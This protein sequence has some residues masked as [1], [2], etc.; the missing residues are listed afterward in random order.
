MSEIPTTLDLSG[1]IVSQTVASSFSNTVHVNNIL[2]CKWSFIYKALVNEWA[3]VNAL[4]HLPSMTCLWNWEISTLVTWMP[5][6]EGNWYFYQRFVDSVWYSWWCRVMWLISEH[7]S[8][9]KF[10]LDKESSDPRP[11]PRDGHMVSCLTDCR[12]VTFMDTMDQIL[13]FWLCDITDWLPSI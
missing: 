10:M 5:L 3:L 2:L 11:D 6:S 12:P 4:F 9:C 1:Q 13:V 8:C 7:F